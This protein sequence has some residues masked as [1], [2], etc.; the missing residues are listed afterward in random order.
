VNSLAPFIYHFSEYL[1]LVNERLQ[2]LN[3][4]H[5]T[6]KGKCTKLSFPDQNVNLHNQAVGSCLQSLTGSK[7]QGKYGVHLSLSL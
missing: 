7:K 2:L 6:L 1:Y 4:T 5:F 3:T